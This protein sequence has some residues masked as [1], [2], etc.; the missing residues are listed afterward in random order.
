ML[1]SGNVPIGDE[2]SKQNKLPSVT[3]RPRKLYYFILIKVDTNVDIIQVPGKTYSVPQ[4]EEDEEE[5]ELR[6]LQAE[7]AM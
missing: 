7:M 4:T 5:E 6:R 2:V 1:S 3:D